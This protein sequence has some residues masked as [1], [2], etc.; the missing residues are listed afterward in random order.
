MRPFHGLAHGSE[1]ESWIFY[2][3]KRYLHTKARVLAASDT[4]R[5]ALDFAVE[6]HGNQLYGNRPYI[7]HLIAVRQVL[8][9]FG[10]GGDIGVAAWLHDTIEDCRVLRRHLDER[11]GE[12]ISDLVLAVTGVGATRRER[13]ANVYARLQYHMPRAIPPKIADRIANVEACTS[14]SN[15]DYA[16]DDGQK[17]HKLNTSDINKV[18]LEMYREEQGVF[19]EKLAPH[20]AQSTVLMWDRLFEALKA[21]S[22]A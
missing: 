16:S 4:E 15:S 12:A 8:L 6:A 20:G 19:H 14:N 17:M 18:K 5:Q 1:E 13:N 21:Q 9:D 2:T 7:Y 22:P 11:F 10:L 3:N